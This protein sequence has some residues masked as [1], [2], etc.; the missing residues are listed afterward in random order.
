MTVKKR[1]RVRT[2]GGR[3]VFRT[4]KKKTR[5]PRCALCKSFLHGIPRKKTTAKTKK[6]PERKFAGVLCSKCIRQVIKYKAR[7]KSKAITEKDVDLRYLK[8]V[9]MLK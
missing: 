3:N 5:K 4:V 2:P 8:Y 7:L 6:R 9:K 1:K